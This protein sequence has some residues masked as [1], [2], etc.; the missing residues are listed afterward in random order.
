[1]SLI[2]FHRFLIAAAILFCAGFSGY[3]LFAF[4]R[5]GGTGAMALGVVFAVL[6]VALGVYLRRLNRFLGMEEG[7]RER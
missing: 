4:T 3:E 7:E 6:A 1:M 2:G 5:P